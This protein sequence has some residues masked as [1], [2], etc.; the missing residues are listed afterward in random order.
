MIVDKDGAR[1][2]DTTYWPTI[3]GQL[4][5]ALRDELAYFVNCIATGKKPDVITPEESREA[6]RACLAAEESAATGKVVML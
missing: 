3:H 4:R 5:G 2:P 1:C 6:V